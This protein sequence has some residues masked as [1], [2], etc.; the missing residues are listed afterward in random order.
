VQPQRQLVNTYYHAEY[1]QWHR[2]P[3]QDSARKQHRAGIQQQDQQQQ[4]HDQQPPPASHARAMNT[5]TAEMPVGVMI[6]GNASGLNA[7]PKFGSWP[8][9]TNAY[10]IPET[11]SSNDRSATRKTTMPTPILKAAC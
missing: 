1:L 6:N 8:A 7:S 9:G 5:M 11:L 10:A 4:A 2:S 3:A